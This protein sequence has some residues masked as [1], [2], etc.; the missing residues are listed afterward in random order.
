MH[1][2]FDVLVE[3]ERLRDPRFDL[4]R[5]YRQ[6]VV[7]QHC[8]DHQQCYLSTEGTCM[9]NSLAIG[10]TRCLERE[11]PW[12]DRES[13]PIGVRFIAQQ[14][15]G[16]VRLSDLYLNL[17]S[18]I[19][20]SVL[21][22]VYLDL[23]NY[24]AC[25]AH[26][27]LNPR[28]FDLDDLEGEL[29]RLFREPRRPL[30]REP[31]VA[32]HAVETARGHRSEAGDKTVLGALQRNAA[33]P[34]DFKRLIPEPVVVPARALIDSGS[35]SDFV[36][37]KFAHQAGL[38][39]FELAKPLPVHLAVQGSRAKINYGCRATFEYQRI[40]SDRYF[41][42]VNL[43]NYDVILGTP[44]LFQHKISLGLNPTSVV[45]SSATCLPIEGK[46]VRVLQSH[47]AEVLDD[48]LESARRELREY[49]SSICKEASDS[50][51]PPL[52]AI[53]HRIPLIDESKIYSWRPSK[54][55]DAHRASWIEKRDAYLKSG[56]FGLSQNTSTAQR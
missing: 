8:Q 22:N 23:P 54:C 39:V 19:P 35:L 34:R 42:V 45:V 32:L 40:K 18:D 24:Y 6:T 20:N 17:H 3:T 53:N 56:R 1:W 2:R 14:Y 41:D 43:L 5:W 49:A 31:R 26:R 15:E 13:D 52:R 51:L 30:Q 46:Q 36:S 37:S 16:Y 55:P 28:R 38:Q 12:P 29:S 21:E 47:A 48:H 9:G 7:Q 50:P 25:L 4:P 33:A 44:F 11:V 27:R 10:A